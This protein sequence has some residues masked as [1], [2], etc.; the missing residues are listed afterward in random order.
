[1]NNWIDN[2]V[3]WCKEADA[4]TDIDKA[5]AC[6]EVVKIIVDARFKELDNLLD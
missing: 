2:V 6:L 5:Y 4:E 3:H 1:M